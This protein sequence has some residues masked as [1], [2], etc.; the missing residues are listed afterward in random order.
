MYYI[1]KNISVN[2]KYLKISENFLNYDRNA[3]NFII[4]IFKRLCYTRPA[5][6]HL[7]FFYDYQIVS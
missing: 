5:E 3:S 4:E 6:D 7:N 2:I 1:I